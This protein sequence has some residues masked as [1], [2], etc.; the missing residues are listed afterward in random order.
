MTDSIFLNYTQADLHSDWPSNCIANSQ[1]C[2]PTSELMNFSLVEIST[3]IVTLAAAWLFGL[4]LTPLV[5]KLA[6]RW[7][8]VDHP[9]GHR[10]KQLIA[11]CTG[12]G[13]AVALSVVAAI[14]VVFLAGS[15]S[16]LPSPGV[17]F[18]E[19]SIFLGLLPA[20]LVLVAVGLVDDLFGLTGIYKVFGQVLAVSLLV[21][22][23]GL[24]F[25][26][27]SLFWMGF[28]LGN[29]S[30]PFTLF[31]CLGAINALNLID[32][33][34][35]LA[36]VVGTLSFLTLGIIT[37]TRGDM[38]S[39]L[40][41]FAFAGALLGFLR[42]NVPPAKIYLGDTGSMLIGLVFAALAIH[43]S[44]KEQAT[45]VLLVPIAICAIPIL[46]AGAA[47]VRRV[48]T[49]QSVFTPD[50]GHLHHSLLLRG[51]SVGKTVAFIAL[52]T[53][54]TCAGALASY[55]TNQEAYALVATMGV[56][57]ALATFRI[58][59][60]T[61]LR[62]IYSHARSLHRLV[63][64][65]SRRI[66][67]E[68]E[69]A[70]HLQGTR[71]WKKIWGILLEAAPVYQLSRVTLRINIPRLHESF[72]GDWHSKDRSARI[73]PASAGSANIATTALPPKGLPT[74]GGLPIA[75][76]DV[77][78][79]N[80]PLLLGESQIGKLT[81]FGS[82]S[83][84]QALTEMQQVLDFLEPLESEIKE[85]ISRVAAAPV[86]TGEID[87][88]EIDTGEVDTWGVD[89]VGTKTSL[90]GDLEYE[91]A[92]SERARTA[93]SRNKEA[94]RDLEPQV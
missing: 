15:M 84:S 20:A 72:Y 10:K 9:D 78:Q 7:G 93:P 22:G 64:P 45:F 31:F 6:Q 41:C 35:G 83:G 75:K 36:S 55:F 47:L 2:V 16:V 71:H 57:I 30:V 66:D 40:L 90:A 39:V 81:L 27:I 48:T 26:H 80:L 50:R 17:A 28:P 38:L 85:L 18:A 29:L 62:L 21:S 91:T 88:G 94:Q 92:K 14:S 46:D 65:P 74:T 67:G 79:I 37:L 32:G 82:A 53:A 4:V 5:A 43:C 42:Y 44:V 76:Q 11:V 23:G 60:H 58:F 77:W 89:A 13:V 63:L 69:R 34:D 86:S 19:D 68:T 56:F 49:G 51:W 70:I 8:A 24:H 61:E 59:G 33:I 3:A 1:K 73:S 12:G 87:T 52:L 54:I 25:D